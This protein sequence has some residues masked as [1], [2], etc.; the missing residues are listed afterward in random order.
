MPVM[1]WLA[2]LGGS[3]ERFHQAVVVRVPAGLRSDC[4]LGALQAVV[5]HHDALRLRLWDGCG[6]GVAA[7]GYARGVG[8]GADCLRRID[9]W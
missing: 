3:I 2:E 5:D 8:A 7:G 6:R 1:R 4:L 9:A